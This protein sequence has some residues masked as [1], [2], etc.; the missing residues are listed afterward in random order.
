MSKKLIINLQ[1]IT[2]DYVIGDVVTPVLRGINL[3]VAEGDSIAITGRS[4]SGKSTMMNIVG[5]LDIPTS[6]SYIFNG[7]KVNR[8]GEDKLAYI[9]NKEIGFVFQSFNLLARSTALD[10]VIL[11]ATYAGVSISERT[12]KA[13]N[14]LIKLGMEKEIF[15]RP[16]QMSGGQQQRVAIA[17]A[18]M[19]DPAL[20]LAD[21][22]TGNLDTN[23]G[24]AVMDILKELNKEGKTVVLIT[25]EADIA[26]QAKKII[27]LV[28][29]VISKGNYEGH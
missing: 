24:R 4:G 12:N 17:R 10:N 26:V 27:R 8:L 19:N 7:Q 23:S 16:N 1:N 28:D 2:K 22:P 5:L 29:G 21:E 15:K 25:H 11:P 13:K 20:I 3:E 14:L 9:R 18:L 6:G